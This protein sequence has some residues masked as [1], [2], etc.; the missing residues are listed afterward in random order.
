MDVR[1]ASGAAL[2]LRLIWYCVNLAARSFSFVKDVHPRDGGEG[3][4]PRAMKKLYFRMAGDLIILI[5]II[6]ARP[7]LQ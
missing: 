7:P 3:K 6:V 5:V 1:P 4:G 2:L